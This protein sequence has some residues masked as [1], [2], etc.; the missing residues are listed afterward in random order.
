MSPDGRGRDPGRRAL[1]KAGTALAGIAGLAGCTDLFQDGDDTE[2]PAPARTVTPTATL[3]PAETATPMDTDAPTMTAT[4]APTPQGTET[5]T[6]TPTPTPAATETPTPTPDRNRIA[7]SDGDADDSFGSSVAVAGDGNTALVGAAGDDDPNGDGAGSAY[8]FRRSGGTWVQQAKL[9]AADDDDPARVGGAVAVSS[10]GSTAL[11]GAPGEETQID[12]G[13][14]TEFRERGGAAYVFQESGGEWSQ[15]VK[16]R[17]EDSTE[18]DRF[19]GAV[20]LTGDGTTAVVGASGHAEAPESDVGAAFVFER[21]GGAWKEV[22]R[23]DASDRDEGDRFGSSVAVAGDGAVVLVGADGDD[24]P[25]GSAAGSAYV[26]RESSTIAWSREAKI[27]PDGGDDGDRFGG[28]AALTGDGTTALVG[29]SQ[30]DASGGAAGA[31]YVFERDGGDWPE[32]DRLDASDGDGSDRFGSS[33]ALADDGTAALVGA[34][35]DG[36]GAGSAYLLE[37]SEETWSERAKLAAGDDGD[38]FGSSVALAGDRGTALVGADGD[39]DPNGNG[40]GS[41]YVFSF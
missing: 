20:A 29:A 32:Q 24:E 3:T 40:A 35:G 6:T 28:A 15:K 39:E 12:D 18:D 33:V 16:I 4:D 23:L 7:A 11:V 21:R 22:Q 27:A 34:D 19:G 36:D 14:E 31:A 2:T 8:V 5:P 17:P 10:D 37:R 38:S 25:N 13:D 9:A 41:A 1:L 30:R 26:F